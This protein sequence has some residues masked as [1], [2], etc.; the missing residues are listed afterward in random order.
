MYKDYRHY[1]QSQ[2]P[3]DTGDTGISELGMPG[4]LEESLDGESA[5]SGGGEPDLCTY[6]DTVQTY[7]LVSQ[8]KV[9]AEYSNLAA[10]PRF[11]YIYAG[12]QRIGMRDAQDNLHFFINDHLGSTRVLFDSLGTVKDR[13]FYL[14]YG[15]PES[16]QFGRAGSPTRQ[17][18]SDPAILVYG[19]D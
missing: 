4:G 8:G 12:D 3:P 18:R 15:A 1:W 7:Y 19:A 11:T 10:A 9:Q 5:M 2:C 14:A 6:G 16:G 17:G 13:Y